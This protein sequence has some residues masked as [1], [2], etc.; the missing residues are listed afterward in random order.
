MYVSAWPADTCHGEWI[1]LTQ[2]GTTVETSLGKET[3]RCMFVP[4]LLE[5][6]RRGVCKACQETSLTVQGYLHSI[7]IPVVRIADLSYSYSLFK[8]TLP[9]CSIFRDPDENV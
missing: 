5:Y 8:D 4:D 3:P 1:G 7:F 6:P 9:H 2:N